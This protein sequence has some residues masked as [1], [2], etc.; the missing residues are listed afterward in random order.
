M[1]LIPVFF[2]MIRRPP[3]STLFPYTTL[4]RSNTP[5]PCSPNSATALT[6]SRRCG[7]RER[8]DAPGLRHHRGVRGQ[9]HR[10]VAHRDQSHPPRRDPAARLPGR[11]ADR[12]GV[13]RRDDLAPAPRRPPVSSAGPAVGGRPRRR[14][15]PREIGR[16]HV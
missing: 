2:L 10:L 14:R 7:R 9:G 8:Y 16:A 6:T 4:F 3:R 15:R 11:A 1:T 12:R 5:T 13:L